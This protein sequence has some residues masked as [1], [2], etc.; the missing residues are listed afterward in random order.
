[1][2]LL[3]NIK[4][5]NYRIGFISPVWFYLLLSLEILCLWMKLFEVKKNYNHFKKI[6]KFDDTEKW[7]NLMQ[8]VHSLH[9]MFVY[10]SLVLIG[11]HNTIIDPSITVMITTVLSQWICTTLLQGI[12]DKNYCVMCGVISYSF[13]EQM[14]CFYVWWDLRKGFLSIFSVNKYLLNIIFEEIQWIAM[15]I[16]D[17]VI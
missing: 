7:Y 12:S 17:C 15:H 6:N 16:P 4:N 2:I 3:R 14:D 11:W 8:C 9:M 10:I 1:M 13:I 5:L